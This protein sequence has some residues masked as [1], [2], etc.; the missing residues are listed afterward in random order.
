[1]SLLQV[2]SLF[3]ELGAIL[4]AGDN[5]E[6]SISCCS[7]ADEAVVSHPLV[8]VQSTVSLA[9]SGGGTSLGGGGESTGCL[10]TAAQAGSTHN[11][12]I[13]STT[14]GSGGGYLVGDSFTAADLT[15]ACMASMLLCPPGYGADISALEKV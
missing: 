13:G 9:E 1:M 5:K 7:S 10:T 14:R 15:F 3:A 11:G 4:E 12:S 2:R 6:G 8:G